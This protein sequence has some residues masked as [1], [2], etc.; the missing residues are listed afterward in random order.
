MPLLLPNNVNVTPCTGSP[1]L[2]QGLPIIKSPSDHT[3]IPSVHSL[4]LAF[5][6][7]N[8]PDTCCLSS[9]WQ[10]LSCPHCS[11]QWAS[12]QWKHNLISKLLGHFSVFT[13]LCSYFRIWGTVHFHVAF[14]LWYS[15]FPW[16]DRGC[17]ALTGPLNLL[18]LPEHG[19]ES[20]FQI[21]FGAQI[22]SLWESPPLSMLHLAVTPA[23][24]YH[25]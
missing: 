20:F 8:I 11:K 18:L 23:S 1:S 15:F 12:Q 16:V 13:L 10:C 5:S 24:L 3:L 4:L 19:A 21:L 22:C 2:F 7:D 6:P 14:S 9:S 25:F 17:P